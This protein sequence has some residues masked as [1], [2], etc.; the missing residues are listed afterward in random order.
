MLLASQWIEKI[1]K[2]T[3]K[4]TKEDLC[5]EA[6]TV[7][8]YGKKGYITVVAG[9]KV[10]GLK[11]GETKQ[12][13]EVILETKIAPSAEKQHWTR[14]RPT[15]D[16]HFTLQNAATADG[17][18]YLDSMADGTLTNGMSEAPEIPAGTP[19]GIKIYICIQYCTGYLIAK[20]I[21]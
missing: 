13:T 5:P 16:G 2:I 21:K 8:N 7:P 1:G 10:M 20:C 17:D 18:L 6:C 4:M 14:S 12:G 9:G 11:G 19:K 3:N 15:S